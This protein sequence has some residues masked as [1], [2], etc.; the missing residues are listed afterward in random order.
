MGKIPLSSHSPFCE[1]SLHDLL[2]DDGRDVQCK[3]HDRGSDLELR[4]GVAEGERQ[5]AG[6]LPH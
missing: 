4:V 2:E 5:A 6:P 1:P 3:H